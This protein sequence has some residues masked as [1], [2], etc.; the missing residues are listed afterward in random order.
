MFVSFVR[1]EKWFLIGAPLLKRRSYPGK[2]TPLPLQILAGESPR[3]QR[4]PAAEPGSE[5]IYQRP[6]FL[7]SSDGPQ[8]D[9]G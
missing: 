3:Q 4:Q 6:T 8:E 7:R 1:P 9:I 5:L 2:Q